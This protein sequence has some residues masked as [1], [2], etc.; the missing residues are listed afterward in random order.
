MTKAFLKPQKDK[1]QRASES[2]DMWRFW[3]SGT[4][5]EHINSRPFQHTLPNVSLS[6]GSSWVIS[7][8]GNL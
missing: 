1:I 2:E 4:S 5:K 7:F 8:Y 3:D 6:P